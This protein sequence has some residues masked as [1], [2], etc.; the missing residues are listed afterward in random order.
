MDL[1]EKALRLLES[2][3]TTA[4]TDLEEI[5]RM[6]RKLLKYRMEFEKALA[7]K[8]ASIAFINYLMSK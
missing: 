5:L 1:S 2:E 8:Q 4:N 7:D 6:E 3:Y